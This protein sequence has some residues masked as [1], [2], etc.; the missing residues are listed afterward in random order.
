MSSTVSGETDV[1]LPELGDAAAETIMRQIENE[2]S[3]RMLQVQA[4]PPAYVDMQNLNRGFP[5][6]ETT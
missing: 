6:V 1:W 5:A 3:P 4:T 2:G